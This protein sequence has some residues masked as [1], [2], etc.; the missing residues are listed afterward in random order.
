MKPILEM[1]P[2]LDFLEGSAYFGFEKSIGIENVILLNEHYR[3]HPKIARWF[4]QAFYGSSLA[5]MTEISQM[6]DDLRGISWIDVE[7]AA[8]RPSNQRSWIN[9]AEIREAVNVIRMCLA[10]GLS[11]GVVSPFSAQA[12]AISRAVESEF[13]AELLSE[14]DF[15]AGTAHRFQG[16]ERDVI[17]FSACVAPGISEHAAKWVEKERNLIN[18]AVSRARQRLVV[19]GTPSI[20]TLKCPTISSLRAFIL[21]VNNGDGRVDHRVDSESESR[22]LN[23]MIASGLSPLAKVDVEGFEL[24]FAVM[25]RGRRIDLEVDGDQ[26]FDASRQQCRQDLF[27]DRVLTRA[28]W[29]VLRFPAWRC[30]VESQIVVAEIHKYLDNRS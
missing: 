23:A 26:H 3:C 24:D 7:G 30:F 22:L 5:V 14:V 20:E 13:S 18:V 17:I 10:D 2:G 15:S 29:E 19:L 9:T 8:S 12:S 27:R 6:Q 16:D 4:N 1:N 21:D 11:I 28:G 25:V